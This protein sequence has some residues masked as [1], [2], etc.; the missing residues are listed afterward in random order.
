MSIF[1]SYTG[2]NKIFSLQL[3]SPKID[4]LY[5]RVQNYNIYFQNKHIFPLNSYIFLFIR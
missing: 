4:S 3:S 2:K 1:V 5:K